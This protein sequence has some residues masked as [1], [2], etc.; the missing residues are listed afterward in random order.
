[1]RRR[2]CCRILLRQSGH[3]VIIYFSSSEQVRRRS[4]SAGSKRLLSTRHRFAVVRTPLGAT[5][6]GLYVL[7]L[8]ICYWPPLDQTRV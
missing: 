8:R 1:M 4:V 6:D 5:S 2:S 7:R 3:I